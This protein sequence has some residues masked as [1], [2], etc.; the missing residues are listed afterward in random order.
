MPPGEGSEV[1]WSRIPAER[2]KGIFPCTRL[3][4]GLQAVHLGLVD[5]QL[6]FLFQPA[7]Q[8]EHE[9][10]HGLLALALSKLFAHV[11]ARRCKGRIAQR[12]LLAIGHLQ[13]YTLAS[14]AYRSA[15]LSWL[16]VKRSAERPAHGGQ[17][18]HL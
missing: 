14:Q 12:S 6:A 2:S 5:L 11:V 9:H 1:G 8:V 16:Q 13:H 3:S 7:A 4:A 15:D 17:I 10:L 18:G